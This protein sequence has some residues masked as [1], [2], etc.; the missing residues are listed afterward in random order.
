MLCTVCKRN[1]LFP[2]L[3]FA[4]LVARLYFVMFSTFWILYLTSYVG[5]ILEDD[6][7]VSSLYAKLMMI[8]I[9]IGLSFSPIVGFFADRVTPLVMI[10]MAFILRALAIGLFYFIKDPTHTYAFVVGSLLVLG[11]TCE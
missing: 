8:S 4:S 7:E 9:I 5:T 3:F 2:V 10:P 1:K 11:T 6:K